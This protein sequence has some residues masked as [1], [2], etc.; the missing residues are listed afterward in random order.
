[1]TTVRQVIQYL[2]LLRQDDPICFI[3]W[4]RTTVTGFVPAAK[5]TKK[6]LTAVMKLFDKEL[7]MEGLNESLEHLNE[8]FNDIIKEE[9]EE[10]IKCEQKKK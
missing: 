2:S 7:G 4:D 9:F 6:K 8:A 5:I 1:M 10:E 3:A